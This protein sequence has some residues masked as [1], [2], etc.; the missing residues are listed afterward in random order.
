M[1]ERF[2]SPI[3]QGVEG[4]NRESTILQ[5]Q[6]YHGIIGLHRQGEKAVANFCM[7][8]AIQ[9]H[10]A[11]FLH[12]SLAIHPHHCAHLCAFPVLAVRAFLSVAADANPILGV[13]QLVQMECCSGLSLEGAGI[14]QGLTPSFVDLSILD[15]CF[16][17]GQ[18]GL[19]TA[20]CWGAGEAV[21]LEEIQVKPPKSSEVRI[22]LLYA[23]LSHTDILHCSGFHCL[24]FRE[25][26]AMK[27]YGGVCSLLAKFPIKKHW[28]YQ[29]EQPNDRVGIYGV[30]KVLHLG[31]YVPIFISPIAPTPSLFFEKKLRAL[32][33]LGI[34]SLMFGPP[35]GLSIIILW[36]LRILDDFHET[37]NERPRLN[38]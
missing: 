34:C 32:S 26:Q 3:G 11:L 5:R 37:I 6:P 17:L 19:S 8:S 35:S 12:S 28:L 15:S 21:K 9:T 27:A 33:L 20:A 2:H 24:C 10:L 14:P 38:G 25:F 36:R 18:L 23:S 30:V 1:G 31:R 22:K 16:F 4:P 13:A 29:C 7:L